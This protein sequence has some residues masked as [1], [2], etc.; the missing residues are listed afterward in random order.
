MP[1]GKRDAPPPDTIVTLV[2]AV[3]RWTENFQAMSWLMASTIASGAPVVA[4]L[5][6]AD[7]PIVRLLKP[8]VCTPTTVLV[9]PPARPSKVRPN[10]STRKL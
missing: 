2:P 1:A 8:P 6:I 7:T 4:K 10:R 5:P 3:M 9:T